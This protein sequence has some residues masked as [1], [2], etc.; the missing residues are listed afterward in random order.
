MNR[1]LPYLTLTLIHIVTIS[2]LQAQQVQQMEFKELKADNIIL[3]DASRS[4]LIVESTIPKL[5]FQSNRGIKPNAV[6][7]EKSGLW[8]IYLE[9]GVQLVTILAAG[10]LDLELGRHNYQA[11]RARKI[12]VTAEQP[13]GLGNLRIETDPIGASISF[14]DLP[15]PGRTP[16]LL[17]NQPT[18][19]HTI[20]IEKNG[21]GVLEETVTVEKDRTVTKRFTLQQEYSGMNITS[22]PS[23]AT[24]YLNGAYLGTTPLMRDDLTPG[25]GTLTVE[26]R[27]YVTHSQLIR[28]TAG[29]KLTN[30]VF[31]VSQTGSIAVTTIPKGA[32]IFLDGKSMGVCEGT[33]LAQDKLLAGSHSVRATMSGFED[34]SRTVFVTFNNITA[35]TLTFDKPGVLFITSSPSGASIILNGEDTGQITT[36]SIEQLKVGEYDVIIRKKGYWDVKK[37]INILPGETLTIN[38]QLNAMMMG[39]LHVTT[40]PSGASVFL[41]DIK[42]GKSPLEI[43]ELR[44]GNYH[45]SLVKKK[46]E[47]FE[48]DITINEGEKKSETFDLLESKY[49]TTPDKLSE[50]AQ[51]YPKVKVHLKNGA[52]F[53]GK[54]AIIDRE[55]LIL[56]SNKQMQTYSL[57]DVQTVEAKKNLGSKWALRGGGGCALLLMA[58]TVPVEDED[59]TTGEDI[60]FSL[61]FGAMIAVPIYLIGT[62]FD[63]WQTV[64]QAPDQSF[65][66]RPFRLGIRTDNDNGILLGLSYN[67]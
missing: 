8:H 66:S 17:D 24:V 40:N 26:M 11:R 65:I 46:Y 29:D 22:D 51:K 21:Y 53:Y 47:T 37:T 35:V 49:T 61:I 44:P 6:K 1:S 12:R 48:Q 13:E 52:R 56:T 14:N 34:I 45:L 58:M 57:K 4:L 2:F 20:R 39:T 31:L 32:E 16:L 38:E 67:F 64:Y 43:K 63:T 9:P 60:M 3:D 54:K 7:E 10:Y 30:T 28:L 55:S 25:E 19:T 18:G 36:A 42:K 62:I 23:G 41:D 50:F 15:I 27:G 5:M 59:F 33:A